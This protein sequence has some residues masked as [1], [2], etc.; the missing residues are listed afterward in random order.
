MGLL[1]A[2]APT[3][4]PISVDEAKAF[5]RLSD[6]Q[7]DDLILMSIGAARVWV[8]E[9]Y[10]RRALCTQTRRL[11]LEEFEGRCLRLPLPPLQSVTSITYVDTAGTTQTWAAANYQ[12]VGAV[13]TVTSAS[14]V[15]PIPPQGYVVPAYAQTWP[16]AREQPEAVSVTYVCGY[17]SSAQVPD[18]IKH[19]LKLLVLEMVE[20]GN[21]DVAAVS[22]SCM[23]T[24]ERLLYPFRVWT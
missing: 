24:V 7:S 17:G 10:L 5:C 6:S 13:G 14:V 11:T 18:P 22:P 15:T 23:T 1:L 16:T 21:G 12:V 19:A 20:R 9:A 2:T 4:E 3:D 8:E